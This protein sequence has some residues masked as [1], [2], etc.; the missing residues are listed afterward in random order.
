VID[1]RS[2]GAVHGVSP[3]LVTSAG[4]LVHCAV[5]AAIPPVVPSPVG[6]NVWA[7]LEV[8]VPAGGSDVLVDELVIDGQLAAPFQCLT[9]SFNLVLWDFTNPLQP[10]RVATKSAATSA[11]NSR[12]SIAWDLRLLAGHTYRFGAHLASYRA[13]SVALPVDHGNLEVRASAFYA[14]NEPCN[15]SKLSAAPLDDARVYFAVVFHE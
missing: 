15:A 3:Q 14:D 1:G 2:T 10:L 5:N 9:A 7:A 13:T 12:T 4:G 6:G 8:S 11:R